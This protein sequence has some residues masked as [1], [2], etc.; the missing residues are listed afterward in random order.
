MLGHFDLTDFA[1]LTSKDG[2]PKASGERIPDCQ[3]DRGG[4]HHVVGAP[5]FGAWAQHERMAVV[6]QERL[7]IWAQHGCM[8]LMAVRCMGSWAQGCMGPSGLCPMFHFMHPS[9]G[10][11][12]YA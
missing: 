1:M 10:N 3:L 9:G 2:S 4:G 11:D 5:C 12:M 7:G 6:V 8:W